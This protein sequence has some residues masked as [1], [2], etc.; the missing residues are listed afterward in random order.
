MRR[1]LVIHEQQVRALVTMD[2]AVRMMQQVFA[3]DAAGGVQL[4]PAVVERLADV[5]ATFGI[6]SGMLRRDETSAT[7][8]RAPARRVLGLKAGGY[9]RLNGERGLPGHSSVMLLFDPSS[10]QPIALIAAN[11][12]TSLRTG[13][14]G[15]VAAAHLARA[16]SHRIA[17][18]GAGDQARMQVAAIRHVRPI[19]E[20]RV[21]S[22]RSEAAAACAR[23]W[24]EQG[25]AALAVDDAET[26]VRG[27]DI[28]VTTTP[29]ME[30][31]VRDAWIDRG[32]HINAVGSD[33][34]GKRELDLA[35]L[36]RAT[37]VVDRLS[38]SLTIGE[39]Q[40]LSDEEKR[41]PPVH[42]ELKDVC[43]GLKPGRQDD[44]ETT[45]FDSTGVSFQD[46][47]VAD[48]I[49]RESQARPDAVFVE[50]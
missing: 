4:F 48:Y 6:K 13:A 3:D 10:G 33:A 17:V 49:Y 22:R 29:S 34:R 43:A 47:I 9:W 41:Q 28:V 46:L 18:I 24:T 14:A 42:A 36:R 44:N 16:D 11:A 38:Q 40:H 35:L 25:L 45:V 21:W 27:A 7:G 15:G 39:L 8:V 1:V 12:I 2:A 31:L 50:I 30:P 37:V 32:T 20:V 26:A 5:Q 19:D 23:E